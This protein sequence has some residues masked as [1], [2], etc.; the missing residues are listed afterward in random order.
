[1]EDPSVQVQLTSM[2]GFIV[3]HRTVVLI[4]VH[5]PQCMGEEKCKQNYRH[6]LRYVMIIG[7]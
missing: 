6:S 4:R 5:F 3:Q 2:S 7:L 1:M